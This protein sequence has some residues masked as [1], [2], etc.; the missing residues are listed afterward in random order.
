ML[1][2][3]LLEASLTTW[4]EAGRISFA[5]RKKGITIP[6]TDLIIASLAL[7]HNCSLL[8]LDPHFQKIPGVKPFND[9]LKM[10]TLRIRS[11][12][13]NLG[14]AKRKKVCS[15]KNV[16]S[17]FYDDTCQ[18]FFFCFSAF[19]PQ[20]TPLLRKNQYNSILCHKYS[21]KNN[22]V[23]PDLPSC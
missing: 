16:V 23:R 19:V 22:R 21:L 6:T 20:N 4:I 7:E 3:P 10:N 2:L 13:L 8:T 18:T 15:T 17:T 1:A 9:Q 12:L 14:F 11:G 5:L